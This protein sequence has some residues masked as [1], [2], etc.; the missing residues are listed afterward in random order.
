[1]ILYGTNPI[2]W[3][4]DD[5]QT[6][7]AD[8]SFEQCLR[9]IAEIGFDGTEKGHKFPNDAAGMRRALD[10]HGLKFV[11]GWYSLNLLQ[12]DAR[13]EIAAMQ[14]HLD[15]LAGCDC[16]VAILCETTG[17]VHGDPAHPITDK[18]NMTEAEW[19]LFTGRLTEVAE[20]IAAL[21]ILPVYHHHMGTV[22]QTRAE[23]DRLMAETGPALRL[24]FDTGHAFFAGEDPAAILRDHAARVGHLHM[25]N[26]R[27]RV[28]RQVLDTGMSFLDGVRAGVFTVPGDPEGAVDF[29]PILKLAAAQGYEGWLVIEAEQDPALRNP[30]FYQSMGLKSLKETARAVGLDSA[31]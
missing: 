11:S 20:H 14:S 27:P 19:R 4:N 18:P 21:G 7:G 3:S 15:L 30:Y 29:A 28:M 26:V 23:I 16:R 24:L 25:K 17:C 13:A 8:I 31:G 6:L 12:R 1:M 22:V 10:P 5:D 2:A 9:E